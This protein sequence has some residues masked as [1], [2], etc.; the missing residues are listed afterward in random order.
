MTI[1]PFTSPLGK[2]FTTYEHRVPLTGTGPFS[3]G[4]Y[5]LPNGWSA[6]I[7]G[8]TLV[9]SGMAD[10]VMASYAASFEVFSCCDCDPVTLTTTITINSG[11]VYSWSMIPTIAPVGTPIRTTFTAPKTCPPDAV[12]RLAVF[13]ADGV[14][15]YIE[16][17]LSSEPLVI[18]IPAGTSTYV[19]Q[20]SDANADLIFKPDTEQSA[21]LLTCTPS[22]LRQRR[23]V[24]PRSDCN[25][26]WTLSTYQFAADKPTSQT[27]SVTGLPKGGLVAFD[28]Y[29]GNVLQ[30]YGDFVLSYESPSVT[31]GPLTFPAFAIGTDFNYRPRSPLLG[32]AVGCRILPLRKDFDVVTGTVCAINWTLESN[33]FVAGKAKHQTFSA[34]GIPEGGGVTFDLYVDD[35]LQ[36]YGDFTLTAAVPSVSPGELTFPIGV[37]GVNFNYRPRTPSLGTAAACRVT[38]TKLPFTVSGLVCSIG[39]K[40]ESDVFAANVAK[41]QTYSA[42]G[43]P[44]GGAVAFDLYIGTVLQTYGDFTLTGEAPMATPG[45]LTFPD[46]VIGFDFNYRPRAPSLGQAA[47]CAVSPTK[48]PFRVIAG[49]STPVAPTCAVNWRMQT[50]LF[51]AGV[52]SPQS[53]TAVGL[54]A[55]ASLVLRLYDN[56]VLQTYGDVTLSYAT[57]VVT[58]GSL[59]FPAASI[60]HTYTYQPVLPMAGAGAGCSV[61]PSALPFSVQASA[62]G[63]CAGILTASAGGCGTTGTPVTSG[64]MCF[65]LGSC[66]PSGATGSVT[67]LR[68]SNAPVGTTITLEYTSD[69]GATWTTVNTTTSS[70]ASQLLYTAQPNGGCPALTGAAGVYTVTSNPAMRFRAKVAGSVLP[71]CV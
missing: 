10:E 66:V 25:I 22:N 26:I 4:E 57:P 31:V 27:F 50:T 46:A 6:G 14:T 11:C 24:P 54:V 39:W 70:S 28:L 65:T 17:A 53:F 35:V 8:T 16:L 5:Y 67:E 58:V 2:I 21:C 40:L 63:A 36:T 7:V 19:V 47:T 68:V 34:T 64:T 45:N 52:A 42:T 41:H 44:L 3:I 55:G 20:A 71:V 1:I 37:I 13:K 9:F 15:P 38:P 62:T 56:G 48:I 18:T 49:T 29:V 51:V 59:S 60:G 23:I 33:A 43:I 32:K 61:T 69:S 30:D 12:L